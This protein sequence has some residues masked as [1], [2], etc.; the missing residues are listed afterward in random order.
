MRSGIAGQGALFMPAVFMPAVVMLAL[1]RPAVIM[2]A[3]FF[4]SDVSLVTATADW[5]VTAAAIT[6]LDAVSALAAALVAAS[7]AEFATLL[8][9]FLHDYQLY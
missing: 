5:H 6:D 4:C 8:A 7:A 1:F 9:Q 3:V 2:P